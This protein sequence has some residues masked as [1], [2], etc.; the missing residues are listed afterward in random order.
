MS[1]LLYK[2]IIILKFEH[3]QIIIYA[4]NFFLYLEY[5]GFL[6]LFRVIVVHITYVMQISE[7]SFTGFISSIVNEVSRTNS[8][9]F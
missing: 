8:K 1:L 4:Q 7:F 9:F 6:T 3:D 2:S 5:D